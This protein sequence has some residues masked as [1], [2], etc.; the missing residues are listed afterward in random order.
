MPWVGLRCV[1]VV[2]PDHTHLFFGH[3]VNP[4]LNGHS[5]KTKNG[6]QDRLSLNA[7]QVVFPDH[8]HMLFGHTVKYVLSGHSKRPKHGFQ[9]RLSLNA[10]QKFC[11]ML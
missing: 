7:G 9:D 4:V 10:G 3:T 2:F 11:R 8:T 5:K 1:I 6:F